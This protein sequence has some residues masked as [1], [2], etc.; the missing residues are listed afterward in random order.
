MRHHTSIGARVAAAPQDASVRVAQDDLTA[1]EYYPLVTAYQRDWVAHARELRPGLVGQAFF[2]QD[3]PFWCSIFET[4]TRPV[5]GGLGI[6]PVLDQVEKYLQVALRLHETAHH[7]K[8]GKQLLTISG[9][10]ALLI[11]R[12]RG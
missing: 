9:W 2:K 4:E 11:R 10:Y 5:E 12:T 3:N 8:T 7:P 1:T 6:Q